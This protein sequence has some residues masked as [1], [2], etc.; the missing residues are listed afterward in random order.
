MIAYHPNIRSTKESCLRRFV[1]EITMLWFK[2]INWPKTCYDC[3]EVLGVK[4]G[5]QKS[6]LLKFLSHFNA[7]HEDP[8]PGLTKYC[9]GVVK[10]TNYLFHNLFSFRDFFVCLK[11]RKKLLKKNLQCNKDKIRIF[12]RSFYVQISNVRSRFVV[13]IIFLVDNFCP[14]I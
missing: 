12:D 8:K 4:S 11:W 6:C 13:S 5:V 9:P 2:K 7:W 3:L 10:A 1:Y 14:K